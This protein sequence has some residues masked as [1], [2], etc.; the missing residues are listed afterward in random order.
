M[1]TIYTVPVFLMVT[2][3]LKVQPPNPQPLD[4]PFCSKLPVLSKVPPLNFKCPV[5]TSKVQLKLVPRNSIDF[6]LVNPML[7]LST[8]KSVSFNEDFIA[9]QIQILEVPWSCLLLSC[10]LFRRPLPPLPPLLLPP[11]KQTMRKSSTTV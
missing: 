10:P 1:L 11:P 8:G 7:R 6:L 2:S 9:H 5:I 3:S 4:E